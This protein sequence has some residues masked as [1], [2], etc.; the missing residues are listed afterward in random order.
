MSPGAVRRHLGRTACAGVAGAGVVVACAAFAQSSGGDAPPRLTL[1]LSSTLSADSNRSL[2]A[3]NPDPGGR[4]DTNLGFRFDTRSRVDR[5]QVYADSIYRFGTATTNSQ[6]GNG[7]QQPKLRFGYARNTGNA[8]LSL[9]AS[10]QRSDVNRFLTQTLPGSTALSPAVN[11]ALTGA[12]ATD[13]LVT[14]PLANDPLAIDPLAPAT[15]V[16]GQPA[17]SAL[18]TDLPGVG[19]QVPVTGTVADTSVAGTLQ[20]GVHDPIGFI[21]S[22]SK[23]RRHYSAQTDSSVYD[24]RRQALSFTTRLSPSALTAIDLNV[25]ENREENDNILATQRRSRNASVGLRQAVSPVLSLQAELGY[26][27]NTTDQTVF[28]RQRSRRSDGIFGQAA[29]SLDRPNGSASLILSADRD[30]QGSRNSVRVGR[31]FTLPGGDRFDGDLGLSARSG[32]SPQLVGGVRYAKA[33]PAGRIEARFNRGI[34]LNANDVNVASTLVGLTISHEISAVSDL[35]LRADYSRTNGGTVG[36][37]TNTASRQ[38]L[39]ASYVRDLTPDWSLETG[40]QYRR[41]ND[42]ASRTA[43]SNSVFLTIGRSFVALR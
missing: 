15:L 2:S 28:G 33:L 13:P 38:S 35:E 24:T 40:Y 5:L 16:P 26:G 19:S 6:I 17:S 41:L 37:V 43:N 10:Y 23:Y 21:L 42:G 14:D 8:N 27:W 7:L 32:G 20:T 4:L 36:G 30:S 39:R 11:P 9:I 3:A 31:I 25:R 22:A 12:L 1:K 34:S 18:I 29:F